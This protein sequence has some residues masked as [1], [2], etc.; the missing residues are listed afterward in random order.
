MKRIFLSIAVMP[1]FIACNQDVKD[2]NARLKSENDQLTSSLTMRDSLMSNL[3]ESFDFIESNLD[4]IRAKEGIIQSA[5]QDGFEGSK[6]R[7]EKILE[8]IQAIDGFI[9]ENQ[10]AIDKLNNKITLYSREVGKYKVDLKSIKKLKE[11][12]EAQ[13]NEKNLEIQTL[14]EELVSKNFKIEELNTQLASV[15]SLSK[16]QKEKIAKQREALNTAYYTVGTYKDLKEKNVVAKK[17]GIIGIGAAKTLASDFNK[18][19]F[20]RIDITKTSIIPINSDDKVKLI[21]EHPSD[22][23]KL[24][25]QEDTTVNL[26]ITDL[27]KFWKSS[28]YL[29][30]L[31]E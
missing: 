16:A 21:S 8:D 24:N 10:A 11:K 23:Y 1:L 31:I 2:E 6:N 26:E 17:G 12:L 5:Q 14:K 3:S 7:K 29:V 20:T 18:D 27:N 28:K 25:I 4:S 22:S 9:A 15:S 19:H 13:I 30:V